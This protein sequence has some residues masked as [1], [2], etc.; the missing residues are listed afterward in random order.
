MTFPLS[1][2]I[3]CILALALA[4]HLPLHLLAKSEQANTNAAKANDSLL[5]YPGTWEGKCQD[6]RTFVV[7]ALR[8][9]GDHLAGT[10]SIGNMHGDDEGACMLVTAPPAP[11]H[12]LKVGEAVAHNDVL[13]F[14]GSQSSDSKPVRFEFKEIDQNKADLKLLNTPVEQH[15]WALERVQR[16][17]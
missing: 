14:A 1:G 4:S 15:P 9:E 7:L 6:G 16:P 12:A 2:G 8:A 5:K 17:D 13:S 10:V 3:F 11:E